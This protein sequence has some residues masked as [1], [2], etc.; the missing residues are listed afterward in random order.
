MVAAMRFIRA[1]ALVIGALLVVGWLIATFAEIVEDLN[2]DPGHV[3]D[4][5]VL[6]ALREAGQPNNPIGP[7]WFEIAMADLT[8]LGGV[9]T[10]VL[11]SLIVSGYLL[12]KKRPLAALTLLTAL[13]GGVALSQ[14]LK[15]I[16]GRERPP[17][18]FRAVEAVNASF[19]SGH[20]MLSAV[21]FLT[22]GA[23]LAKS[24][25]LR[26]EKIYVMVV[27]VLLTGIIGLSRIY[28]GVHWTTDV[29]AGW[30]IGIAWATTCWLAVWAAE[31]WHGRPAPRDSHSL[32]AKPASAKSPAVTG[33]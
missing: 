12:L 2:E 27:A 29:F 19:P 22:L 23:M 20:A 10:L 31:R 13:G 28:L 6:T 24:Q 26:R 3:W 9:A 18:D 15:V 4:M 1:E 16:F 11:I 14:T 30:C 21:T 17:M 33:E 32:K 5:S 7:K 25:T 8:S